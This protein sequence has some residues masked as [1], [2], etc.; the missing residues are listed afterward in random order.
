MEEITITTLADVIKGL[1]DTLKYPLNVWLGGELPRYGQT[2]KNLIF[3]LEGEGET[4]TELKLYF[5]SISKVPAT[6]SYA[7]RNEKLI[8]LRLYNDGK[9]IIDKEK[10]VYTEL[11]SPTKSPPIITLE[12]IKTK[13]PK[14]VKWKQPIFMTGSLVK[15]GW[16]GNDVDFMTESNHAEIRDFF[17]E[18]L[19]VKVD[20]GNADMPDRE[21]VYKYLIY[22]KCQLI[23]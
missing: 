21:P 6:V 20:V 23:M 8:A 5:E 3:L 18:L 14:E 10:L 4:S 2:S 19:G 1:P 12:E 15:N 13:L 11:P 16:S 17:T 22:D 7:W 9:L